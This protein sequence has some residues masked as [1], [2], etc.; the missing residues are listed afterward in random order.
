MITLI[1]LLAVIAL[2]FIIGTCLLTSIV[3]I[4]AMRCN[5]PPPQHP[6]HTWEIEYK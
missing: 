1:E 2:L 3:L 5:C 4:R 6:K